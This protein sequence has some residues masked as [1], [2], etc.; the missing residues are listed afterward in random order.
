MT[1]YEIK[2]SSHS[3]VDFEEA[4]NYYN[5]ISPG[6]GNKFL[7]DYLRV[8]RAISLNPFFASVKYDNIRCAAFKK[9]PF[10]V[11]YEINEKSKWIVIVAVFNTWKEPFW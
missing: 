3:L 2:Y 4:T 7:D 8:Y 11:H 10:S 9:F 6:L 5:T 1:K